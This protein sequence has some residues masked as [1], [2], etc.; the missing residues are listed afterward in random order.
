M[1]KKNVTLG[2]VMLIAMTFTSSCYFEFPSRISGDG[3]VVSE[4]RDL[5]NFSSISISG[6][7]EGFI[8]M[9]EKFSV[10]VIADEN[11]QEIIQTEVR[12]KKL[13]IRASRNIRRADSKE[14]HISL[15]VLSGIDVS[16]AARM[17]SENFFDV[18]EL[19][20]DVSSA[21]RLKLI[22]NSRE[23]DI[24]VSS[25]G[26]AT[27][28]GRTENLKATV[29]SAGDLDASDLEAV[30]AKVNVSSAGKA[31]LMVSGELDANASSAGS[32][33]Y[34]GNPIEKSTITSSAGSIRQR[35][36]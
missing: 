19:R 28:E 2:L 35:G 20:A 11:L 3:N 26:D 27:L 8:T 25:A 17:Q 7:L 23:L 22:I 4:I 33:S 5:N 29:S 24:N 15:P 36:N 31:S 34:K 13:V 12:G 9:G 10:E 6:G 21:G 14:V 30:N 16:S 32:I 1:M 18:D